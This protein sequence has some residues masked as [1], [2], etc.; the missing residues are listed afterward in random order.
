MATN[1]SGMIVL[2]PLIAVTVLVVVFVVAGSLIYS[3]DPQ[4]VVRTLPTKHVAVATGLVYARGRPI[5][6]VEVGDTV[7][8]TRAGNGL[9]VLFADSIGLRVLGVA[10]LF[11][12]PVDDQ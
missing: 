8:A 11:L 3:P 7:W 5:R 12:M 10:D 2:A 4:Y 9:P 6:R 1:D